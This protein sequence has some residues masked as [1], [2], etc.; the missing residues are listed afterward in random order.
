MDFGD[1]VL[2]HRPI[3]I[4]QCK[5]SLCLTCNTPENEHF[6]KDEFGEESDIQ[7]H[8]YYQRSKTFGPRVVINQDTHIGKC[9]ACGKQYE[10]DIYEFTNPEPSS[11][12]LT[13][14][15]T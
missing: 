4:C 10:V 2:E 7:P 14:N 15:V 9:N 1:V 6:S 5:Y 13:N 8:D 11:R 12:L 3:V